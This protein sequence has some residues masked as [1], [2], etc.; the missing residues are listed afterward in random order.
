MSHLGPDMDS[1]TQ[2]A[3]VIISAPESSPLKSLLRTSLPAVVDL[4]S[5]TIMWTVESIL[6]GKISA[7]AFGGVG[8]ALQ[9]II[10]CITV[11][12]TFVVGSSLIITRHLGAG[13]KREANHILGQAMMLG[14]VMACLLAVFWYFGATN[15]LK[16]IKEEG[17]AEAERA[18]VIYLK[19]LAMF[20]PFIITNFIAVGIVR[21][22]GDTHFSML[23]N[24][25]VNGL[26]LIM[27][28]I[29]IFGL[30][31][32]PRLEVRGAALAA[33]ICHTLGFCG[34]LYL[35]RSHK[36]VLFLCF[37]EMARPNFQTFR[38]LFNAGLPTTIE[39]LVW[40]LGQLVVS[41][42]VARLGVELLAAHQVFLRIQAILSMLYMGFGM[43]AMTLMG[44]NLGAAKRRLAQHTA[45]ISSWVMFGCVMVVV[46]ILGGFSRQIMYIFTRD[47]EVV[48]IGAFVMKVFALAQIPKAV[49]SALIG[50]LRGA[51]DLRW[52][53]WTTIASAFLLEIGFNWFVAF[54][55][56]WS[57]VGLWFTQLLDETSRLAINYWRFKGGK[58]KFLHV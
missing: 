21:G 40:A 1:A 37:H 55:F 36:S 9:V 15:I 41:G 14:V 3:R 11:L 25:S 34:T 28:P 30:F 39:Q 45:E 32:L 29:L 23:I 57:L 53:M 33:G 42:Y 50:N 20:A 46:V 54:V 16:L 49:D 7:E 2:R 44:K 8:M 4:A 31:G 17:G 56:E 5:Q 43:G 10:L 35:L 26:N 38:R 6:I 47:P 58:W 48:H 22:A 12:I 52:L 24:L 27:A 18:G 13:D 19:T 51:G